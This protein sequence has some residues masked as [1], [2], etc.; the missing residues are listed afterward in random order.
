MSEYRRPRR[1]VGRILAPAPLLLLFAC[2][3]PPDSSASLPSGGKGVGIRQLGPQQFIDARPAALVNG[4]GVDWGEL[5]PLLNEAAGATV[6]QEL[7]LDRLVA[8]Q[9]AA[10]GF[11]ID[12]DDIEVEREFFYAAL[13]E[14]PQKAVLLAQQVK[15]RQGLGRI[16]FAMRLRTN[17]GLRALVRSQVTV[18]DASVARMHESV[19]GPKR[20]ARLI[21]VVG[22]PD[23]EA[24]M[25]RLDA[26]ESFSDIAVEVSTDPSA[27]RG[28]LLE[29]ISRVDPRYP[30][31]LRQALW[32]LETGGVSN[33]V[34]LDD[35]YALLHLVREI[36]ADGVT[37]E[38]ARPHL[39]E[40]V[41][42][43]QER[44]LMDRK[45]R[46]LAATVSVTVID[47]ALQESWEWKNR[48]RSP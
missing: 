31:A 24:V 30:E 37:L 28:G 40:L 29:P 44:I 21:V 22:L 35:R 8:E 6:L 20:Q 46:Q 43:E 27:A 34:L 10:A 14:D 5:R 38:E 11:T 17:A 1:W 45:A 47:D 4:R 42:L 33:P 23:A 41:R 25:R 48:G 32:A 3:T 19:H 16:R 7:I 12:S 39:R 2:S 26:G 18:T 15:E 9:T 13:D 36:E